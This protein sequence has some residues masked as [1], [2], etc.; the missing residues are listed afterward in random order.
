MTSSVRLFPPD[1]FVFRMYYD[2]LYTLALYCVTSKYTELPAM[3]YTDKKKF[4][5]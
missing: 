3:E 2:A 5:N 1:S 4:S